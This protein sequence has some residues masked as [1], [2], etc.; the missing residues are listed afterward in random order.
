M[1]DL[2]YPVYPAKKAI[3]YFRSSLLFDNNFPEWKGQR[4]QSNILMKIKQVVSAL[5]VERGRFMQLRDLF[6]KANC[7]VLKVPK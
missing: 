3:N 1:S 5:S 2:N 4:D 7:P 6:I